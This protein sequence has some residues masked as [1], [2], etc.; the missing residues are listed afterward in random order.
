[1]DN[2]SEN[3]QP[4]AA[5]AD[6]GEFYTV[7]QH[8]RLGVNILTQK[9]TDRTANAINFVPW[10]NSYLVK[11]LYEKQKKMLSMPANNESS[12]EEYKTNNSNTVLVC[13][14]SD[15]KKML[16]ATETINQLLP[17][18]TT[19]KITQE[20]ESYRISVQKLGQQE[21]KEQKI[22]RGRVFYT[23]KPIK[24]YDELEESGCNAA[25]FENEGESWW[26][27]ELRIK[28]SEPSVRED[29]CWDFSEF[30]EKRTGMK[31]TNSVSPARNSFGIYADHAE[32]EVYAAFFLPDKDSEVIF[33]TGRSAAEIANMET[34]KKWFLEFA[35]KYAKQNF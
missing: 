31:F 30:M 25:D 8:V 18:E 12:Q 6:A 17:P 14:N 24:V 1:M 34:T 16:L 22:S 26:D 29:M 23:V 4:G 3:N 19:I 33:S 2:S 32:F 21:K 13:K 15:G 20:E 10:P 11:E 7:L 28:P 5:T 9:Q 27:L 35:E